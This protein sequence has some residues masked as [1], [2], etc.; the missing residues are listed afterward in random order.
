MSP[1]DCAR[2]NWCAFDAGIVAS[3]DS[4][5]SLAVYSELPEERFSDR[6][7]RFHFT[8]LSHGTQEIL[9]NLIILDSSAR[10]HQHPR[11]NE[12]QAVTLIWWSTGE[13]EVRV[14]RTERLGKWTGRK[15][16]PARAAVGARRSAL[17]RRGGKCPRRRAPRRLTRSR[18]C[19]TMARLSA[20]RAACR[21]RA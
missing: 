7:I 12:K 18:C 4:K 17:A 13:L 15:G 14:I 19:S 20:S 9:R 6:D 11:D 8:N 16:T 10:A 2:V 5:L 1:R 3:Y 21:T